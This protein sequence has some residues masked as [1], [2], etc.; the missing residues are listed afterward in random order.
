MGI[1][2][3]APMYKQASLYADEPLALKLQTNTSNTT[4]VY[5]YTFK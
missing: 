1:I 3:V 4:F 5:A 2:I